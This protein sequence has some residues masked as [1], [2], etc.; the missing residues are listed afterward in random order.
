MKDYGN[1][2]IFKRR[3]DGN[4]LVVRKHPP[5]E[6]KSSSIRY[7]KDPIELLS[8]VAKNKMFPVVI[9]YLELYK[10][11][12]V[13]RLPLEE[14]IIKFGNL[15]NVIRALTFLGMDRDSISV[16]V[17]R[18]YQHVRTV[19]QQLLKRPQQE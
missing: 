1:I 6:V 14:L 9:S 5:K 15:S 11:E 12:D 4:E 7:D 2:V 18:K 10:D 17:K 13:K 3:R 8:D 16:I 19:R